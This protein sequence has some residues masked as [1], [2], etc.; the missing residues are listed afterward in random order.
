MAAPRRFAPIAA[1]LGL[2]AVATAAVG[3]IVLSAN[4][5]ERPSD[6]PKL[7]PVPSIARRVTPSPAVAPTEAC[8][9][10]VNGQSAADVAAA[11]ADAG[12]GTVCFPAGRY[13]GPFTVGVASQTWALDDGAILAGT[14][15][16]KAPDVWIRGGTIELP[17]GDFWAEGVSIT[18]DRASIQGVTFNGGGLVVSIHGRDGTQVLDSTFSGQTGTAIFIWGEGRGAND[19]LIEGN[20]ISASSQKASPIG[21]RAAEGDASGGIFNRGITIRG[22]TIDQGDGTT[23]H[24]GV[25]LKLSPG[26]II[27]DNDI[28]GGG[29]LISLPDSDG[30]IVSG[31]RLNLQGSA[32]W[33]VE[34]AKSNDVTVEDNTF[35]GDGPGSEDAAVSMNTD[36]LR[37]LISG[38]RASGLGAFVNL[39]GDD[40]VIAD[41][42]L[43]DVKAVTAYG[44][45]AGP[46]VVVSRNGPCSA[47]G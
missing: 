3:A 24:F 23:G 31:N 29:A 38:N 10:T 16:I 8:Q 36:S 34:I 17:T 42:C 39:T 30:V 14:I 44:A 40:H 41:N 21:S 18:A 19:T 1:I 9:A 2:A 13:E 45:D 6:N 11:A 43:A 12:A 22:N 37:A 7:I 32:V 15:A 46:N 4:L 28:R 20:T 35:T 47:Q 5:Q 25:E 33:G 27:V 26:A